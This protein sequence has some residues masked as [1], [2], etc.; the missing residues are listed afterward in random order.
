MSS[1]PFCPNSGMYFTTGSLSLTL[2]CSTNCITA[3]VVAT[4]LVSDAMSKIVSA[5]M[6]VR[7]GSRDRMPYA[8]R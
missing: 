5:D 2:P 8:L 6:A 1:L 4:T 7:T 3:V